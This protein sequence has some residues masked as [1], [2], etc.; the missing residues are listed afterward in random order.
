VTIITSVATQY[1]CRVFAGRNRTVVAGAARTDNLGMINCKHGCKYIGVVAILADI[2]GLDV[3]EVLAGC[4][5]AVM[6]VNTISGDIQMIE[7][8]R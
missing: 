3:G 7:I 1:V 6:A 4:I 2:R 8:R 5:R